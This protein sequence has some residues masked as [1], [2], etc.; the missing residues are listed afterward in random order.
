MGLTNGWMVWVSKQAP[1]SKKNDITLAQ[2][3]LS[4]MVDLMT[5]KDVL[6]VDKGFSALKHEI[7]QVIVA[8]TKPRNA[9]LEDWQQQESNETR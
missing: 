4:E 7:E 8:H 1:A 5:T 6:I 9:E 3:H 2:E